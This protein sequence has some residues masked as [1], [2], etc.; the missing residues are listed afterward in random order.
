MA[1]R[2]RPPVRP[3]DPPMLPFALTG[4]VVWAVVGTVLLAAGAPADWL[5][6]C[7]AGFLIGIGLLALAAARG[8]RRSADPAK[9]RTEHA[10]SG[11]GDR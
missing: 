10:R 8:R 3:L 4:T 7:L 5:W 9:P 1:D 2:R 6:T 11:S